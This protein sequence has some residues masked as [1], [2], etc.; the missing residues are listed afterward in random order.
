[1]NSIEQNIKSIREDF[2]ILSCPDFIYLDSAATSQNPVTV[3]KKWM[4]L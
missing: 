2:P 1:M 3:L 4:G